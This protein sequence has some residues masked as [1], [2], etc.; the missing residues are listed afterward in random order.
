M[1]IEDIR[2]DVLLLRYWQFVARFALQS[3]EQWPDFRFD[4][5]LCTGRHGAVIATL[6]PWGPARSGAA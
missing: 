2:L 3:G 5:A 1:V 6:S 4:R